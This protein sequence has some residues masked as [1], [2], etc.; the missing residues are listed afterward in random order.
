MTHYCTSSFILP[1]IVSIA[2]CSDRDGEG[3][4]HRVQCVLNH[5]S[6]VADGKSGDAG[7]QGF[8]IHISKKR[9][10]LLDA[11]MEFMLIQLCSRDLKLIP[12][13]SASLR[14]LRTS[15]HLLKA[16]MKNPA[17]GRSETYVPSSLLL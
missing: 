14:S 7:R 3:L 4:P 5:F 10:F 12:S 16:K 11:Q 13:T 6:L 1:V 9:D 17:R 15:T 8:K 2:E